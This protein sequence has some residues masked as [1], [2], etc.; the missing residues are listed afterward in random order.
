M[1]LEQLAIFVA[2]AE[3]EH[4]TQ[5]AAAVNLTPSA[6][7][8]AIRTLEA[9][10]GVPLFNRVGRRI[11]LSPE[12]RLFL[13]EA[14]R[15]LA[16]ARAAEAVLSDLGDLKTGE[17][18]LMASQTVANYWLPPRLLEFAGSYPGITIRF[19]VGNTADVARAVTSGRAELGIIEGSMDEPALAAVPIVED[20]LLIVTT[21][22]ATADL[23]AL[24]WIMREPG[25]GTR[26]V[27]EAAISR[28]GHDPFALPV[29][30]TLP[31][32]EAVLSAV[33]AS[34][35]AAALSEMVVAPF[36]HSGQLRVIGPELPPRQFTLLRHKERRLS[37]A[38][39]RFEELCRGA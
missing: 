33:L 3:R 2:V 35:C 9:F 8:S 1:T 4:L 36:I 5:G 16:Q 10:Y 25:S 21:A 30:L 39:R 24:R 17:L 22:P 28:A 26:A 14:R 31:T 7:S 32:N 12:G 19:T 13:D 20:R 11:E 34:N 18:A 15:T 38:A 29:A 27:F 6:A 37:A 23:A